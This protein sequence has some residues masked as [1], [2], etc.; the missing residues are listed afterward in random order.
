[1]ERALVR[2]L[3][4]MGANVTA[5]NPAEASEDEI[6]Q[7]LLCAI[8]DAVLMDLRLG[9]RRGGEVWRALRAQVPAL[10]RRVIFLSA[11]APGDREWDDARALGQP[12]LAKPLDMAELALAIGSLLRESDE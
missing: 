10:A 12:V 6:L 7:T 2:L 1:V 8:P 9:S 5:F 11:L 3:G 4:R